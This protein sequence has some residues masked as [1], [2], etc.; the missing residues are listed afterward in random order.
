MIFNI[1]LIL[2]SLFVLPPFAVAIGRYKYLDLL[3]KIL[4]RY[5]WVL[6]LSEILGWYTAMNNIQNHVIF[7]ILIPFEFICLS[8]IYW[9]AIKTKEFRL[10]ILILGSSIFL[11]QIISNVLNWES[12]NRFNSIANALPN[13]GLMFFALLYFYELLRE[14][15]VVKLSILPMFWINSG[16][17]FYV[18]LNFFLFIFGEFVFFNSSK[19]FAKLQVVIQAISNITYRTFLTIGL[20]FSTTPQQSNPSSK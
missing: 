9:I 15:Q 6:L 11:F 20:W 13:L 16:I 19:D 2:S 10:I 7:N 17:L 14:Q 4:Y 8:Y 3:G 5:L 12:F 18:S 1:L